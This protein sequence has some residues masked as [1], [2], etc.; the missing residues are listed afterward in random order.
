MDV[1]LNIVIFSF[2]TIPYLLYTFP[3]TDTSLRQLIFDIL[4]PP[5]IRVYLQEYLGIEQ[6]FSVSFIKNKNYKHFL[7][8]LVYRQ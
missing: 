3:D 8:F 6:V 1:F 7:A 5:K 2:Q 4:K